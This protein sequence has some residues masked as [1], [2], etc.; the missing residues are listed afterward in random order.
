MDMLWQ[1][2]ANGIVIGLG[3]AL[4]ALGLTLILGILHILN[5]AHGE[6]YML[7]GTICYVFVN[8]LGINYYA[9]IFLV[10]LTVM[11]IGMIV[12]RL[13][14]QPVIERDQMSI[15]LVTF[16]VSL[17]IINL[18]HA[19]WGSTPRRVASPLTGTFELGPIILPNQKL[20]I[21]FIGLIL[22][23]ILSMVIKKTVLGKMMRAVAQ[24][25]TG[26]VVVGIDVKRIY[27]ITFT[28]AAGL[29]ALAGAL[30]APTTFIDANSGQYSIMKA[31]SVV[32]LGG[33]GSVPG[34]VL[35]GLL[36][37][38]TET[39]TAGFALSA[40][41]DLIAFVILILVLLIKPSGLFGRKGA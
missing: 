16:A 2:L 9:S 25:K 12:Q 28:I 18:T 19:L 39:I 26:A 20:F 40:F 38:I 3:Y 6:F 1:Q 7:G 36:L 32:I 17:L 34:A 14:I 22:I 35:G 37:G 31:F 41:K 21:L 27:M 5:F 24:N 13:A 23:F 29:A 10:V 15:L 30:I 8:T 11:V 33:M 4:I